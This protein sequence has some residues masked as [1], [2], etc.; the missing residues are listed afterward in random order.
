MIVARL[1]ESLTIPRTERIS[2]P[3]GR[4]RPPAAGIRL[5]AALLVAT[6]FYFLVRPLAFTLLRLP[7][8]DLV[9][10]SSFIVGLAICPILEEVALR[11]GS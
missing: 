1:I 7:L 8:D 3:A 10:N 9:L 11:R 4:G 6:F 2:D 5:A